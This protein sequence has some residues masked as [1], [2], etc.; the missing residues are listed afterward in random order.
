MSVSRASTLVALTISLFVSMLATADTGALERCRA[1]RDAGARLA[2]YDALPSN[3]PPVAVLPAAAANPAIP[4]PTNDF[5]IEQ[6][7]VAATQVPSLDSSIV[8]KFEGWGPRSRIT[9]ANG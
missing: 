2:C 5:G 6:Q 7:R 9:L 3:A 4:A 8:G 1:V